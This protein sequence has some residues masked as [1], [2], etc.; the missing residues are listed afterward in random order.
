MIDNPNFFEDKH[1]YQMTPIAAVG[2]ELWSMSENIVFDNFLITH[3]KAVADEWISETFTLKHTQELTSGGSGENVF[4]W[5]I[6]AAE[7]RKWLYAVY[8][9]VVL[10][11]IVL[12]SVWC[13]PNSGPGIKV[14]YMPSSF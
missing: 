1:P 13:C 5:L 10:L 11:P 9:V 8:I 7:E 14:N 2:L 12:L 3:S 6:K 4:Q